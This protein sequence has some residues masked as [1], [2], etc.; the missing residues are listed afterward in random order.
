MMHGST[1]WR[2]IVAPVVE[3]L[4]FLIVIGGLTWGAVTI[5]IA[6]IELMDAHAQ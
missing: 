1:L 2:Q 4:V 3:A 6:V 5:W